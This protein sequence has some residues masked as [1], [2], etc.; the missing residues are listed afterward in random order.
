MKLP[1]TLI[2]GD[3]VSSKTDYRDNLPVN[4]FAIERPVLSAQG[5]MLQC[6]GLSQMGTGFG[7]D[8]G[9]IFNER[10]NAHYRVSG[11]KFVSVAVDGTVTEL[12]DIP[13]SSQVRLD[14]FYSFNTQAIVAD[15]RM[16][17]YDPIDGFREVVDPDLGS[18]LDGVEID[19]Y[20]FLTDGEYLYHTDLNDESAIDPLKFATAEFM[21]DKSLGV[22]KTPDNKAI[23]FGRYSTEYFSDEANANFAFTRIETRAQKIGIVATHAKCQVGDSWYILGG[24]KYDSIS[25]YRL[26]SGTSKNI[27]TREIDKILKEYSEPELVDVRLESRMEDNTTFIF[28][29]LPRETLCYNATIAGKF[30]DELAWTLLKTATTKNWPYRGI[31]GVFDPRMGKWIY[32]DRRGSAI[33][34]LDESITTHYGYEVEWLLYSPFIKLDGYSIDEIEIETIP[35]HNV[36]DDA[37]VAVSLTSDGV[38]YGS[39]YWM[40]YGDPNDYGKRFILRR[41]GC[42]RGFVGFKF[43]GI[44]SSRMA[45]ALMT[46]EYS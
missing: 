24:G 20:Y 12:G 5:Y 25:A 29:H 35:G 46:V 14:D 39:E 41:L 37:R 17:L 3:K 27:S 31:N 32:G 15:G 11:E 30:G 28:F 19:Q 23:V 2:K 34:R 16:F 44:S 36:E 18:P 38:T 4:M 40:D 7:Q 1:V 33:A 22:G 21:P 9:G 43:R 6:P 26:A 13:G 42:V 8:R 45:F 10:F